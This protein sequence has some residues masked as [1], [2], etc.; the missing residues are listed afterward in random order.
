MTVR[1]GDPSASSE[2][3]V[4]GDNG[5]MSTDR[6][7][8]RRKL[9]HRLS[10]ASSTSYRAQDPLNRR[11]AADSSGL[12][13][14]ANPPPSS[15]GK[16]RQILKYLGEG[17]SSGR[18]TSTQK[19]WDLASIRGSNVST[20]TLG[21]I[22]TTDARRRSGDSTFAASVAG[23]IPAW[24]RRIGKSN[25]PP[26]IIG[27]AAGSPGTAFP[28]TSPVMSPVRPGRGDREVSPAFSDD[29]MLPEERVYPDGYSSHLSV[30]TQSGSES[31]APTSSNSSGWRQVGP[32]LPTV[33]L[34]P[35]PVQPP[36][37]FSNRPTSA[38]PGMAPSTSRFSL[39]LPGGA[40]LERAFRFFMDPDAS[41]SSLGKGAGI[42][43][44]QGVWLLGVWHGPKEPD[45]QQGFEI[46]STPATPAADSASA[47]STPPSAQSGTRPDE[48][49]AIPFP[50]V[51]A[52]TPFVGNRARSSS[53][54]IVNTSKL[55]VH[56][57][58]T[59][60][61]QAEFQADFSSRIWCTYRNHFAPI[62]RDGTISAEAEAG[63]LTPS[64]SSTAGEGLAIPST[65]NTASAQHGSGGGAAWN[66]GPSQTVRQWIGRR[67]GEGGSSHDLLSVSP[68][69]HMN[70][71]PNPAQMSNSPSLSSITPS[72]SNTTISGSAA[73]GPYG[74]F[75]KSPSA[76]S[77]NTYSLGGGS[78]TGGGLLS[79]TSSVAG[80]LGD[81]MGIPALWGRATA[82]AQAVGLTGRSGLT[83]DAGW[84][85]ML[86]TGQSLLA[87]ALM[88]IHLGREWR[89]QQ[90]PVSKRILALQQYYQSVGTPLGPHGPSLPLHIPPEVTLLDLGDADYD[91]KRRN[92][93][94]KWRSAKAQ[95]ARY[96]R[97]ISWFLD[98]PCF[99]CPFSVQRMA[100]EGKRLGKE[101]GEW[102]GPSTAAGA[103]KQLVSEF[104][105]AGLGVCLAV[106][107]VVYLTDVREAALDRRR[108]VGPSK[109][110]PQSN[111]WDRPVLILVNLRLGIDCVHP[112]YYDS[113]KDI[114]TFPQSVGI[115]GG[116]P[117]SS[118]YFMGCQ[119]NTLFY[120]DP[121]NV[122]SA[123]PF[124]PPPASVQRRASNQSLSSQYTQPQ[125]AKLSTEWGS[126]SSS[127]STQQ[128][129]WWCQ[130]YTDAQLSTFHCDKVR[131]MPIKSL[132]PSMLLGFLV[133]T[134]EQLDDFCARV[135][136]LPEPIFSVAENA[137]RWDAVD[138]D[139][140]EEGMESFSES[141]LDPSEEAASSNN[142]NAR[143]D[144]GSRR[145]SG[146]SGWV[147][148]EDE[149]EDDDD[150]GDN[151]DEI[152][153]DTGAVSIPEPAV[154][155]NAA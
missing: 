4:A 70:V 101:V 35:P 48:A 75:S 60:S 1:R 69:H 114:F 34:A 81:K 109:A 74:T 13:D 115:S 130:A 67:L 119:E 132:D 19:D 50:T 143:L 80:G 117:S 41:T 42:G 55:T 10:N 39:P 154:N 145:G 89:R 98:D 62:S 92:L 102:F 87:N 64:A 152:A 21:S 83:T 18:T 23:S 120:L 17:S 147:D 116:R 105:D 20:D 43:D 71:S 84:G 51:T 76:S 131:K 149:E 126:S 122:R 146:G 106:D 2:E 94:D 123:V 26:S 25:K 63:V 45:A 127:D 7:T 57:P 99:A 153:F 78:G 12:Y 148:E 108:G 113:V 138:D 133:K 86:R 151:S 47:P 58:A 61:W 27:G 24:A 77:G 3:N 93:E 52:P 97:L 150:D 11:A 38:G 137:P 14:K 66:A 121:H 129:D 104:P 135:K 16:A 8:G 5:V 33:P 53:Q 90:S 85:C 29:S 65:P 72:G 59:T 100:R 46:V 96:V 79:A 49:S 110:G 9:F 155:Q 22:H 103:I 73:G 95:Y 141:S 111:R 82:A 134:P 125:P 140:D 28:P 6:Q 68:S 54:L 31:A 88:D 112:R 32:T 128:D 142:T 107:Q 144:G 124:Q 36:T 40:G 136:R 91:A 37:Q 44:Q 139:D 15:S 118:Y 56:D 30:S